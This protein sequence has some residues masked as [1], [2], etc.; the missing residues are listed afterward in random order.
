MS[1]HR[2]SA[3]PEVYGLPT[4]GLIPSSLNFGLSVRILP[5]ELPIKI[6]DDHQRGFVL[7]VV[8]RESLVFGGELGLER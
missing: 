6:D 8:H 7:R 4:V 1:I 5:V 3:D 2:P